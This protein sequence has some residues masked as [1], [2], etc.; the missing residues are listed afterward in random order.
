M[1]GEKQVVLRFA[2][3]ILMVRQMNLANEK[4]STMTKETVEHV[5]RAA[6]PRQRRVRLRLMSLIGCSMEIVFHFQLAN[7]FRVAIEFD[8]RVECG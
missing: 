5:V 4:K 7:V 2:N 6:Q 3:L 8:I 1:Y